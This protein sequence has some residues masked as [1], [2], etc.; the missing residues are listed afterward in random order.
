LL[1]EVTCFCTENV[2]RGS[3]Y[4]QQTNLAIFMN[5]A[6]GSYAATTGRYA[7]Q[8]VAAGGHTVFTGIAADL[9][10]GISAVVAS[11]QACG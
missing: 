8:F 1:I 7:D 6:W 3:H 9:V 2:V 10:F 11:A 4:A 5:V